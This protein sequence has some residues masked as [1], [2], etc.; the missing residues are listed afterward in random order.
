MDK[1][2]LYW[3]LTTLPQVAAALV[4]FIGFLALH[5][6]DEP[7]RRREQI[8]NLTRKDLRE[9]RAKTYDDYLKRNQKMRNIAYDL[10]DSISGDELMKAVDLWLRPIVADIGPVKHYPATWTKL[11]QRIRETYR[12]MGVFVALHLVIIAACLAMIPYIPSLVNLPPLKLL[13]IGEV[14]IM[15][16]ATG[17]MIFFSTCRGRV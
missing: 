15:V 16:I 11:N 5:S 4:A 10:L 14:A 7:L 8:E 13:F 9:K 17:T 1:E 2:A 6:L 3:I 12:V